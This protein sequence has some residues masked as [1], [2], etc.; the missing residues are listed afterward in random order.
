MRLSIKPPITFA[1]VAEISVPGAAEPARLTI[2]WR[3]KDR[4]ALRAWMDAANAPTDDPLARDAA[5]LDEVIQDW[6]EGPQDEAGKAV[7]YSRAALQE[8]LAAYPGAGGDLYAA[9]M[10]ALHRGREKNSAGRPA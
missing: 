8:L 2:L 7:P 5:W 3:H 6:P 1:D 10:R 4:R 9:Y